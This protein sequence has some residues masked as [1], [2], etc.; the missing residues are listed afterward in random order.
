MD[1]LLEPAR[2]GKHRRIGPVA[3]ARGY[4]TLVY[5]AVSMAFFFL[6]QLPPLLVTGGAEF[7][8]WLAR[9]AWGPIGL[10][11]AGARLE[12]IR[13][14]DDPVGPAVYVSNHESALDIWALFI[15][16]RRNLRFVA[17]KELFDL[18]VFGWYLRM[19][20]FVEVDRRNHARAV[21]SLEKGA[22]IVREG[23][24]LIVFPEG[25]RSPDG[26]VQA[27]KKGPF[28]LAARAGVPVVPVAITGA[29]ERAPKGQIA[30]FPGTIRV[31]IGA[32]V[33]PALY[34]GRDEL[35]REVRR[36]IIELQRSIG[37]PGG[38][39]DDAVSARGQEGGRDV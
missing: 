5:A 1:A 22:D 25:T 36:R 35:L 2:A 6:L 13:R 9:R 28:V 33:D 11:I 21:A 38:D 16:I 24:S 23:V 3:R 37:G 18:P 12:V 27:F 15:A 29:A 34:A 17:K 14:A 39:L 32:P 10:R 26:H 31:A 19:A 7:S 8:I 20:R 30:V 4:A